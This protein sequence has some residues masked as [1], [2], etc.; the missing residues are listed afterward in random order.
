MIYTLGDILNVDGSEYQIIGKITYRNTVDNCCWDEYMMRS[1]TNG[2]EAWLSID[3]VYS[4]YSISF[5]ISHGYTVGYHEVDRGTEVVV[6]AMGR[7]DVVT[8]DTAHFIEYEDEEEERI[9]SVEMW[10]DGVEYS[11]GYYLDEDEIKLVAEGAK[12]PG[13]FGGQ[14]KKKAPLI[15][16]IPLVLVFAAVFIP[17]LNTIL[18]N[19]DDTPLISDYL[20]GDPAYT[21]LTSVTGKDG[22]HADVYQTVYYDSIDSAARNIIN[23]V[24]GEIQYIQDDNE[25]YELST[26][27]SASAYMAADGETSSAN[28]NN[29][30]E[31]WVTIE[32][33]S[34]AI[35]TEDEYCVLY[36]DKEG[37][38][39]IQVATREYTYTSNNNL[40]GAGTKPNRFYRRFYYS[41]GYSS[42]SS[43]YSGKTSPYSS[44]NDT[45]IFYSTNN[46]YNTYSGSVRQASIN[47][48][49]SSSGGLSGGK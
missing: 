35:L 26:S 47:A 29:E 23:A 5:V 44:F 19:I 6:S 25:R 49:K 3:D 39:L 2:N 16:I 22:Q 17:I 45:S 37:N 1:L 42:D 32:E 28:Y 4:E 31:G 33:N 18:D 11:E 46:S 8:G 40:Y 48:R 41:T 15:A 38:L 10:D 12:I 27:T 34:I 36:R 43:R 14:K 30:D 20:D 7:V 24:D 9:L 21:Y 13:G